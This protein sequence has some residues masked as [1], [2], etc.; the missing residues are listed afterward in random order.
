MRVPSPWCRRRAFSLVELLV[1]IAIVAILVG[2]VITQAP[3]WF[4][5]ARV[6]ES[7]NNLKQIGSAVFLYVA[8]HDG[9][10]PRRTERDGGEDQPSKWP[11]LLLPYVGDQKVYLR[12]GDA[13]NYLR[14]GA[15]P[16]SNANNHTS[17]IMNGWNDVG[18]PAEADI[19]VKMAIVEQPAQTILFGIPV[20]GSRHFY[21]DFEEGNHLNVVDPDAEGRGAP[22]LF[23]DGS[24]RFIS[25]EEY[26]EDGRQGDRLWLVSKG[27]ADVIG[28]P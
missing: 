20:E 17:Y 4:E 23:A 28:E 2:L 19:T 14:T 10:L 7:T 6:A 15:D 27:N 5:R 12:H 25:E 3:R 16:L 24:C 21:M 13:Q 22:Y 1:A 18:D 11:E 26:L 9:A 8:D